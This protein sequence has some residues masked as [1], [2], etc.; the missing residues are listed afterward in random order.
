MS[1]S[2]RK[3]K[4]S[5]LTTVTGLVMVLLFCALAWFVVQQ[6][7]T[8]PTPD[9][10]QKEVRVKNLADLNTANEKALTEYRWIDKAKGVVGIPIERAMALILTDLQTNRPHSAGPVAPAATPGQSPAQPAA[11]QPAPAQPTP[12]QPAPA[13]PAPAAQPVAAQP[14]PSAAN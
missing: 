3:S 13:Q 11:T 4:S 5:I 1:D 7:H 2:I 8:I 9:D 10:V 14:A 6:R 12:G